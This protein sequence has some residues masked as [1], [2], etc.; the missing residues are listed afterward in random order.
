MPDLS[1]ENQ[2]DL[3]YHEGNKEAVSRMQSHWIALFRGINVGGH[4]KLPMKE[5]A[6]SLQEIG[7]LNPR[8]VIQSGNVTFRCTGRSGA[9]LARSIEDA[10][11]RA[12]GFRPPV[13][14]F[15]E[16]G[17][18]AR[19]KAN[20][21]RDAIDVPKSLHLFFCEAVPPDPNLAA[22]DERRAGKELCK[23]DGDVFYLHAPEG[24]G[25]SKLAANVE[26]LLGVAATARNWNTLQ[27]LVALL[28]T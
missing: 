28:D 8:T 17:F 27:R 21:F 13:L 1:G 6:A 26:R 20:P 2:A 10:V 25:R 7:L 22:V 12:H 19:L 9:E 16:S 4:N 5:L 3:V 23:L 14:V 24:I 15:D 18:R 11:E